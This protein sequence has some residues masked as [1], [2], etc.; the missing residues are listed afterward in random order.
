MNNWS[1]AWQWWGAIVAIN[2]INV[3]IGIIVYFK[4]KKSD[5]IE[6]QKYRKTMRILGLIYVLVA[7]YRSIFVSSYLGQLA[8]FDSLAN[9]SLLIRFFAIFSE[10]S[11]A[12]LIM[13]ALLQVNK[14]VPK[15][16]HYFPGRLMRFVETKTPYVFF[17]C[18]C[19]AQLFA[20]TATIVKMDVL[21][22]IEETLWGF[23][24]LSILPLLIIQIRR[25]YSYKDEKAR[26]EFRLF[27]IFAVILTVFT[28]GYCSYSVFYHLPIEYW[29]SAIAQ[30]QMA[31]PIP[32]IRTGLPAIRDAF[33][34]VH[35]TKDL[36]SWGGIGFIIWHSG[37]FSICVWMVLFFMNGPRKLKS[38]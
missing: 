38:E 28:V 10:V 3:A 2:I 26:R 31:S 20:T 29:P 37:Y 30:L 24:F 1:W 34:V 16:A 35:E 25:V 33:F 23:A 18:L 17:I 6:F 15:P 19:T 14:E 5:A 22:A 27:R 13:L 21:F 12:G 9:S 36:A 11:F 32:A 7:L 4:S 8:W